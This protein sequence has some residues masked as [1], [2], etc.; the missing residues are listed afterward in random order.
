EGALWPSQRG[1]RRDGGPGTH[2]SQVRDPLLHHFGHSGAVPEDHRKER[3]PST[4]LGPLHHAK[5]RLSTAHQLTVKRR[6]RRNATR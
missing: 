2:P 1:E 3:V 4:P 6:I 5:R